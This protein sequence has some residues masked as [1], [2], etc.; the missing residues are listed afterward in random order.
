MERMI[1]NK[2]QQ[3]GYIMFHN[4]LNRFSI[5]IMCIKLR[6]VLLLKF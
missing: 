5:K 3:T 4:I 2:K 1:L 6:I